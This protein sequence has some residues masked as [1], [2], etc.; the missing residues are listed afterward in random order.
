MGPMARTRIA[1]YQCFEKLGAGGMGV[2]YRARDE[3]LGRQVAIKVM[4]ARYSGDPDR[5][6]RFQQEA[7]AASA[8]N[9]PNILV[10]FDFGSEDGE[11]YM[12]SELLEGETLRERLA[13]GAIP[14][15]KAVGF[16]LQIVQGLWAA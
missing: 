3:R 4:P 13:S 7:R 10:I 5:L 9:H 8:L 15:P 6:G 12:V 16:A 11:P 1:H 14:P 2:V